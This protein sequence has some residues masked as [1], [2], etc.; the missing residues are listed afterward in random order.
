MVAPLV[1][2]DLSGGRLFF[3]ISDAA[4]RYRHTLHVEPFDPVSGAFI[5]TGADWPDIHTFAAAYVEEIKPMFRT[6]TTLAYLYGWH[7]TAGNPDPLPTIGPTHSTLGTMQ[8][9]AGNDATTLKGGYVCLNFRDEQGNHVPIFLYGI[10]TAYIV[11]VENLQAP[12]TYYAG[13]TS[14]DMMNQ[15]VGFLNRV[16]QSTIP[17]V[18]SHAGGPI[19]GG[20]H[21]TAGQNKKSRRRLGGA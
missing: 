21:A 16:V 15:V 6:T 9:L 14:G 13:A 1:Y 20:A 4:V 7:N 2:T 19:I 8:S 10:C 12:T 3:T 18:W 17:V 5:R 11:N